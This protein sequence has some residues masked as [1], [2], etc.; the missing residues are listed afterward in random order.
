M[1]PIKIVN[2][3]HASSPIDWIPNKITPYVTLP[4]I[5]PVKKDFSSDNNE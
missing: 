4:N 1:N 3:I 5:N 2:G